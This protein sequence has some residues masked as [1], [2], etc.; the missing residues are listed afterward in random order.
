M[1]SDL[2]THRSISGKQT[3]AIGIEKRGKKSKKYSSRRQLQ[4]QLVQQVYQKKVSKYEIDGNQTLPKRQESV[5]IV[6]EPGQMNKTDPSREAPI[7]TEVLMD[8]LNDQQDLDENML[9]MND[10]SYIDNPV[11]KSGSQSHREYGHWKDLNQKSK[12]HRLS[13][14]I[15]LTVINE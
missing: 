5:K 11:H 6:D 13:Q 8:Q 2:L 7:N 3:P 1:S 12:D 15:P 9:V 4:N 10:L 14:E